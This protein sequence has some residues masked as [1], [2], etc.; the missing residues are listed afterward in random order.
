MRNFKFKKSIIEPNP[1]SKKNWDFFLT[2]NISQ[3]TFHKKNIL[4][5]PLHNSHPTNMKYRAKIL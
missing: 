3:I 1:N 5:F 2:T 4:H